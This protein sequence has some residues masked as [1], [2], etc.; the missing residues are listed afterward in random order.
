[1]AGEALQLL[2][3]EGILGCEVVRKTRI[4]VAVIPGVFA[5][6][7]NVGPM[8][9]ILDEPSSASTI[10]QALQASRAKACP[11]A[12]SPSCALALKAAAA[13]ATASATARPA[14]HMAILLGG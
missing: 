10:W 5:M 8:T 2:E 12:T 4:A 13:R 1:M 6:L 11:A 7:R 9:M 14:W 3:V